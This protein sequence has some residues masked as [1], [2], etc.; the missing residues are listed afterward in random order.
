MRALDI[1]EP[2][3]PRAA[4]IFHLNS[5]PALDAFYHPYLEGTARTPAG[6]VRTGVGPQ[7]THQEYGVFR[8]RVS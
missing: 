5:H 8:T 4:L 1:V 6:T 3:A 2:A 7:L